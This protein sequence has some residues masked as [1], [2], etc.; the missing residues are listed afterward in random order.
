MAFFSRDLKGEFGIVL[1]IN[2][3]RF[4]LNSVGY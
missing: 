1:T 2:F 4:S 3:T